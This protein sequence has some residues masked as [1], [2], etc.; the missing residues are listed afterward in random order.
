MVAVLNLPNE[1]KTLNI[2]KEIVGFRKY[3]CFLAQTVDE[4]INTHV[5]VLHCEPGNDELKDTRTELKQCFYAK[6]I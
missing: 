5:C 6:R 1:D 3:V 4:Q 2:L